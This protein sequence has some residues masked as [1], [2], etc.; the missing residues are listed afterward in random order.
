MQQQIDKHNDGFTDFNDNKEEN[1][2]L[3]KFYLFVKTE[4][5]RKIISNV[6]NII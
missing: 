1:E 2:T 3:F 4:N 6:S 5:T